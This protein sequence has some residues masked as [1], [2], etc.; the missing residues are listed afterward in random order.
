MVAL[1]SPCQIRACVSLPVTACWTKP[2]T[3]LSTLSFFWDRCWLINICAK[4]ALCASVNILPWCEVLCREAIFPKS[5][6][7]L[8]WNAY[9][10]YEGFLLNQLVSFQHAFL[11]RTRCDRSPK[12]RFSRPY[13]N[14]H[15]TCTLSINSMPRPQ[16]FLQHG[17]LVGALHFVLNTKHYTRL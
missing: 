1:L 4:F 3:F 5:L 13:P 10:F 16:T 2:Y 11:I 8:T 6:T 9:S 7:W 12:R 15:T 14:G 17:H